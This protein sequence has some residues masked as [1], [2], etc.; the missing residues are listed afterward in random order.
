MEV[1]ANT[2]EHGFKRKHIR[3]ALAYLGYRLMKKGR[4]NQLAWIYKTADKDRVPY[5]M[6]EVDDD[7]ISDDEYYDR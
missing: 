7:D 3:G 5:S 4:H 6:R 2:D 1:Y